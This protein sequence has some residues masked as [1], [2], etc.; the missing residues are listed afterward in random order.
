MRDDYLWDRSGEPDP[1]VQSL[2]SILGNLR[3][4]GRAPQ[5]PVEQ[6]LRTALYR[7]PRSFTWLAAAAAIA[8]LMVAL[9]VWLALHTRSV[10]P[11]VAKESPVIAPQEQKSPSPASAAQESAAPTKNETVAIAPPALP[12]SRRTTV[13]QKQY[14]TD[15]AQLNA[16]QEELT[17]G[18]IAK[19]RLIKALQITS[20]KLNFAQKKGRGEK[21]L[22]PPS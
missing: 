6:N 20:S 15:A 11:S 9:G 4:K 16:S 19:E 1:D 14:A 12:R 22:D 18:R 5:M 2:E 7:R 17:E 8:L 3:H 10:Q 21:E 13:R